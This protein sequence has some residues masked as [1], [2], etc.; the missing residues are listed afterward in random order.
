[1]NQPG[2]HSTQSRNR[3]ATAHHTT[4]LSLP[5]IS[6]S[7]SPGADVYTSFR[8]IIIHLPGR[9]RG[10]SCENSIRD[11][12]CVLSL[13]TRYLVDSILDAPA[14]SCSLREISNPKQGLFSS[15]PP[16]SPDTI[17]AF[18][19]LYTLESWNWLYYFLLGHDVG[20]NS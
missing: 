9:S 10:P 20:T 18:R 7:P 8:A 1:M 14:P 19:G 15:L 3:P 6:P 12:R 13:N 2:P 11:Y 17:H 5:H 4:P 16:L